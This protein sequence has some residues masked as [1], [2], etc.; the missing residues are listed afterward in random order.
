MIPAG[1]SVADM[2]GKKGTA[3]DVKHTLSILVQNHAGVLSRVAALFTRRGY[4]IES[5]AV[6]ATDDPRIARMTIVVEGDRREV[7]QITKNVHKLIEVI[8]VTD[9][10]YE[11]M[12]DRELALIKVTADSHNRS[13]ILQIVDIFRAKIV[14]VSE[15][16]V[17]HRS[18]GGRG[19]GRCDD[20]HATAPRHQGAG[21]HRQ[22]RDGARGQARAGGTPRRPG[23][24]GRPEWQDEPFVGCKGGPFERSKG[25][26]LGGPYRPLPNTISTEGTKSM[27]KMYYDSDADLGYLEGK[28]VAVIGYGSQ[29]HAH[30]QN[31]RDSGI[32][33]IVANRPGQRQLPVGQ[34]PTD[35]SPSR[36]V[37]P[38]PKPTSSS[39]WCPTTCRRPSTKEMEPELTEGKALVFSHGFNI[40]Y[41]QI[42]PPANIDV[43]MVAPKSPGHLVRRMYVEGK[44]V[45]GLLAVHQ[46]ATGRPTIWARLCQGDRLHPGG[47]HRDDL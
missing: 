7:E 17:D 39:C 23:L 42:V 2:I 30:A 44:A 40:H 33:V 8:K 34:S 12:V 28:K 41:H 5:I 15:K 35:L 36:P 22:D 14:D 25:L 37:R 47:R 1:K 31:L 13:E 4:N 6:G 9:L 18:D 20:Q 26:P 46:D 45:P 21:P 43:V 29:G 27:A 16:S 32:D 11:D 38:R 19:Q 3:W 24:R 10:T